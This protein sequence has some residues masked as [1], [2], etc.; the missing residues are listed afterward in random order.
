M[1]T[2]GGEFR[3]GAPS[4]V[5]DLRFIAL[6]S[7][8]AAGSRR[9]HASDKNDPPREKPQASANEPAAGGRESIP[10]EFILDSIA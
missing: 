3:L 7:E 10:S 1:T 5:L 8:A 2:N 9:E 4:R 6:S